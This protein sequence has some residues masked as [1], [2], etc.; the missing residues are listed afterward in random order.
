M[1]L[2]YNNNICLKTTTALIMIIYVYVYQVGNS[3]M[4]F[5]KIVFANI[6]SSSK[7]QHQVWTIFLEIFD[8]KHKMPKHVME[9]YFVC[10]SSLIQSYCT[11]EHIALVQDYGS[12][13]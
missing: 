2:P 1:V 10:M 7:Q 6:S 11:L 13:E 4:F 12:A 3:I 5:P 9:L 8:K